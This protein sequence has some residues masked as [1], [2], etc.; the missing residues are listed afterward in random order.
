MLKESYVRDEQGHS[1]CF[2]PEDKPENL[3]QCQKDTP[4]HTAEIQIHPTSESAYL[5]SQKRLQTLTESS[6]DDSRERRA[7]KKEEN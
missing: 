2:L 1:A 5:E 4:A 3:P 7:H 6:H